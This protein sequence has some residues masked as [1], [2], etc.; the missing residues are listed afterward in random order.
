MA[1][2]SQK[3]VSRRQLGSWPIGYKSLLYIPVEVY[4]RMGLM[5]SL[6]S[7]LHPKCGSSTEYHDIN[8]TK[9]SRH[10]RRLK[11]RKG[12]YNLTRLVTV[13]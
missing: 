4:S 1:L 8:W 6:H 5:T 9:E 12:L 10:A 7:V 13:L 11:V 3:Y 2:A